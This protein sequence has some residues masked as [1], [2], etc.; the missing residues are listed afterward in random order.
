MRI[1]AADSGKVVRAVVQV[2]VST[3]SDNNPGYYASTRGNAVIAGVPGSSAPVEI[4]NPLG[5]DILPTGNVKDTL[6]L[7]GEQVGALVTLNSF[8][9]LIQ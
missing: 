7:D 8:E 4:E 9:S 5:Q 6:T 3:S 2:E 1:L